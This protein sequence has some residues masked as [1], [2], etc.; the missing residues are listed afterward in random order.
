MQ[1]NHFETQSR[2]RKHRYVQAK[3]AGLKQ[4]KLI[5]YLLV[6]LALFAALWCSAEY[7]RF[8][9]ATN[10]V[11]NGTP[12]QIS[13]QV[14]S[15]RPIS[16]LVMGL[17]VGAL[18]RGN[19]GGNTDSLEL[20]TLN[21]KQQTIALTSIP[22]DTLVRV[23]TKYGEDYVKINAAY[24]LGGPQETVR[25]VSHLLDVPINYYAVMNMGVLEKV[26]NAVNGVDVDN[27]FAFTYE[28]HHFPKGEQHL[29]GHLALKYS[30]MRYQDPNND[31]GRQKR[32]QQIIKSAIQKFK[33]SG[34]I[35]SA[36]KIL[37][38]VRD[39]V[40]TNIPV[41]NVATLYSNYHQALKHTKTNHFQG[42]N[43]TIDDV[44]MQI[45]SPKEINR[46]S[47][48]VRQQLG[49]Q[50][51]HVTNEETRLYNHQTDYNGMNNVNFKLPKGVQYNVPH[52]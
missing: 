46:V 52:N 4:L 19:V 8:H 15:G 3:S 20:V 51:V 21:P 35:Y 5:K 12:A 17:D 37:D 9:A 7:H 30:R 28:G 14:K 48:S 45:A 25:Q 11:F 47:A 50:P 1:S 18:H 31:Y 13:S 38:A 6:I 39:G 41:N 32:Q 42:Q 24:S 23:P 44:S 16:V 34:S 36:N 49:L 10:S 29:N 43:A 33:H 40:H 22:R 2:Y 27:P 26:V